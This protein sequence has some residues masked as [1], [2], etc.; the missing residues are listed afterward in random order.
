MDWLQWSLRV[1]KRRIA[2]LQEMHSLHE[3]NR[4][5]LSVVTAAVVSSAIIHIVL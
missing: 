2:L 1:L 3:E 4:T 5:I